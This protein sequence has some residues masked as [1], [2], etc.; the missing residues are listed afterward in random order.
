MS[1]PAIKRQIEF[2]F[3]DSNYRRDTF[4]RAA[5]E[6]DPDGFVPISTLLTF[7]KLKQL[8]NDQQLIVESLKDSDIVL[9][10]E[11][12]TK[13]KKLGELPISD[14][15]AART[16][17]VK[18]YPVDDSEVNIEK[19]TEQFSVYGKI[20]LVKLRRVPDTKEL[21]GSC[22]IEYE[23]EESVKTAVR[24]ANVDGEV[25][26]SYKG[27][28]FLC[29]M[30]Y[31]EWLER[32]KAKRAKNHKPTTNNKKSTE[33]D[34]VDEKAES[35]E[36][37][38][39]K[40]VDDGDETTAKE[41]KKEEK[42]F[43]YTEGLIIKLGNIPEGSNSVK[44]R[45]FFAT[46]GDV[47]FL[48]YKENETTGYIRTRNLESSQK[49]LE[50]IQSGISLPSQVKVIDNLA[51]TTTIKLETE[52]SIVASEEKKEVKEEE[53]SK[54]EETKNE[55]IAATTN[56]TGEV[57]SG[58]EEEEY[59]RKIGS[60]SDNKFKKGGGGGRGRGRG[61]GGGKWGRGRGGGRGGSRKN[62]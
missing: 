35:S 34:A 48:E 12:G 31:S 2:Y 38:K 53:V 6:S 20:L 45:E 60:G 43:E 59:W 27:T 39:R 13:I 5:A 28:P 18:G 44:L 17:Y 24:E 57:L 3:S 21:K 49:I 8:T 37:G 56:L 55:T 61:R 11:D 22:F 14:T 19:V 54:I 42:K 23:T 36:I 40:H 9:V 4:L 32:K 50:A 58:T 51:T 1:N 62:N 10:S 25:K 30:P 7:N 47:K 46:F 41:A 33:G 16:L 15:S 29:V 52:T 26:I